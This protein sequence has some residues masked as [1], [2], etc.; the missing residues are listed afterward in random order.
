M[1]IAVLLFGHLRTFEQC[2][3]G[4]QDN[5]LS[6]YDC[7]VF[8]HTWDETDHNTKS[9]HNREIDPQK[10]TAETEKKIN[11]YYSPKDYQIEHQAEYSKA[12]DVTYLSEPHN[13]VSTASAYFMFYTLNKA[14]QLRKKYEKYHNIKYDVIFATRPDVVL[15]TPLRIEEILY[16]AEVSNFDLN[17]VR[18]VSYSHTTNDHPQKLLINRVND[19]IFFSKPIVMDKYINGHLNLSNEYIQKHALIWPSVYTAAELDSGIMP[20]HIS[21]CYGHDWKNIVSKTVVLDNNPVSLLADNNK[22]N[23]ILQCK[24]IFFG[25]R[26]K[27]IILPM[28]KIVFFP[29][30]CFIHWSHVHF[31]WLVEQ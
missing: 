8:M 25:T 27:R 3:K 26:I 28:A 7:D 6:L 29:L 17:R 15:Y 22:S 16:Q 23:D 9:W 11:L 10:V 21:Y 31:K 19:I 4:L 20:V 12:Q 18:F 13:I 24:E 30:K 5:L 14:N 1:K 2:Y